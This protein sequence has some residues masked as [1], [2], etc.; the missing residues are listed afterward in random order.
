[1]YPEPFRPHG[2][3]DEQR[4]ARP[5]E[6]HT[7]VEQ[8]AADRKTPQP[9]REIH[10]RRHERVGLEA[11]SEASRQPRLRQPFLQSNN[12]ETGEAQVHPAEPEMGRNQHHRGVAS[13]TPAR[14][15]EV[16]VQS[17]RVEIPGEREAPGEPTDE[18]HSRVAG[19]DTVE[20]QRVQ[21]E[22]RPYTHRVATTVDPDPTFR[23]A[24]GK[25][26]V[27]LPHGPGEPGVV[28]WT[29]Q[30]AVQLQRSL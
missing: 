5:H 1:M 7:A 3:Y 22:F 17:E 2:I 15:R 10:H 9:E 29:I 24:H 16:G 20:L 21:Q 18:R 11:S 4:V 14:T 28:P 8:H 27:P 19:A 23:D 30:D 26:A 13:H 25:P 6:N 12:G